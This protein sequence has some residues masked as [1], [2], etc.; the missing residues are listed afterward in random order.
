MTEETIDEKQDDPDRKTLMTVATF[1]EGGL[2]VLGMLIGGLLGINPFSLM[3]WDEQSTVVGVLATLPLLATFAV[4]YACPLQSFQQ[5]KEFLIST[6]GPWLLVCRWYDLI[7]LAALAGF[8][9][10]FLFRGVLQPWLVSL[11][12]PWYGILIVCAIFGV[13]H[14]ITPTYALLAAGASAYLSWLTIYD[15]PTN[16]VPAI[17][18]HAVYDWIAFLIILKAARKRMVEDRI[19][20]ATAEVDVQ[21]GC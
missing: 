15:G 5:I 11:C 4:S 21:V 8:C 20:D 10:E 19:D 2:V 14:M 18:S 13:C 1:I 9:E 3:I 17:I 12:G 16:L 6:F 7:I